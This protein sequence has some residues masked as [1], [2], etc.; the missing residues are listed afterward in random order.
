MGIAGLLLGLCIFVFVKEPEREKSV[1]EI[2][3][4]EIA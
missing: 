2:P 4:Q 3:D 1:E